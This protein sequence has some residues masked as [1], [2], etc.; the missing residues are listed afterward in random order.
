LFA[1]TKIHSKQILFYTV[2]GASSLT[3][4]YSSTIQLLINQA[5]QTKFFLLQIRCG[6]RW[7]QTPV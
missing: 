2:P 7:S 5:E 6:R 3:L 4:I 1:N